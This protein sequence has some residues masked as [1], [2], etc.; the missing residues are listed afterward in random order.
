[1]ADPT[2]I[3]DPEIV[4][5]IQNWMKTK[6]SQMA[7]PPSAAPVGSMD[8]GQGANAYAAPNS[9]P[10]PAP[11]LGPSYG[12]GVKPQSAADYMPET[13]AMLQQALKSRKKGPPEEY[14]STGGGT[15]NAKE[16]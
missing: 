5:N 8:V 4:A 10:S 12:S 14:P 13:N 15:F 6:Q 7:T 3:L 11:S 16:N 1:M 2:N 9:I